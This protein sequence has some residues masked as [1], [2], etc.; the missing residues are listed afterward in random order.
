MKPKIEMLCL[1]GKKGGGEVTTDEKNI[2]LNEAMDLY[3]DSLKRV[4]Y[5]YVRDIQKAE[6]LTQETF[7]KYYTTIDRFEGRSSLKTYLYR[8]AINESINHLKSWN[9]RKVSLLDKMKLWTKK[10]SLETEYIQQETSSELVDK[11]QA[12]PL[13]YR[14]VL[15]LYY[16][17]ELSVNEVADVLSCSPNTVKTR[18]SR[19]RDALKQQLEVD[20]DEHQTTFR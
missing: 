9:N 16:Y 20:F 6:D 1:M 8:I 13:H 14:E 18:L 19:G 17:A 11:L 7:I 15:W 12:I 10:E 3:G 4:I 2:L 5:S